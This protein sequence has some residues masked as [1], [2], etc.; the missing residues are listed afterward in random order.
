MSP[1]LVRAAVTQVRS[2]E[3]VQRKRRH[4]PSY[5]IRVEASGGITL[6][7]VR[8]FAEAGANWISVGALTH[9]AP[10]VDLSF[11]IEPV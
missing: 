5:K 6:A 8:E 1:P 3:H 9:S 11:E 10:G 7:N 4:D 2:A